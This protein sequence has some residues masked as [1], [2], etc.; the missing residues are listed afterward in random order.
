MPTSVPA[1]PVMH[2]QAATDGARDSP[3]SFPRWIPPSYEQARAALGIQDSFKSILSPTD[4]V[5]RMSEIAKAVDTRTFELDL[6]RKM[7][8]KCV[9]NAVLAYNDK[10]LFKVEIVGPASV[11]V[12]DDVS[13]EARVTAQTPARYSFRWYADGK[14]LGSQTNTQKVR[15]GNL[16]DHTISV[17]VWR[18]ARDTG[19]VGTRRRRRRE[20]QSRAPLA[21]CGHCGARPFGTKAEGQLHGDVG[22][23]AHRRKI[24]VYLVFGR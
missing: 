14:E 12:G 10:W 17:V 15:A 20:D 7:Y 8:E 23:R 11:P 18:W 13:L 1:R 3:P 9:Q 22:P 21:A 6:A 5:K 24:W 19:L 2:G 4:A 16:G